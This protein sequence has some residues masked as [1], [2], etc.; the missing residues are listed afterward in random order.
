MMAVFH[1]G[2][3]PISLLAECRKA[4]AGAEDEE[5]MVKFTLNFLQPPYRVYKLRWPLTS[6]MEHFHKFY[7]LILGVVQVMEKMLPNNE[8]LGKIFD[9]FESKDKIKKEFTKFYEA[10]KSTDMIQLRRVSTPVS[11]IKLSVYEYELFL[12]WDQIP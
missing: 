5:V 8:S 7:S 11:S 12:G 9:K 10:S 6:G 4:L 1:P 3:N 2:V